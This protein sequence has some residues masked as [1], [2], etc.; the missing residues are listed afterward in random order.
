M[1]TN[2]LLLL[3]LFFAIAAGLGIMRSRAK[4]TG[5]GFSPEVVEFTATPAVVHPGEPV[6]L[7]WN[8][9]G[10]VSVAMEWGPEKPSRDALQLRAGLPSTGTMT[11][12]PMAD[13]VYELRCYTAAGPM[14]LPVSATVRTR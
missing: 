4:P 13:T 14:C 6:T 8:T 7:A 5:L 12:Q 3:L 11:V 2:F 9:R 10:T 1:K